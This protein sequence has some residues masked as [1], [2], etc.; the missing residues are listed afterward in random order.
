MAEIKKVYQE[1]KTLEIVAFVTFRRSKTRAMLMK[2]PKV[3]FFSKIGS[4]F[5]CCKKKKVLTITDKYGNVHEAA[6]KKA[7]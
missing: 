5:F 2:E 1:D 6:L 7:P 3:T 4:L